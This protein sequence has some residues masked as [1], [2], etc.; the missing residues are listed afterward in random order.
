MRL[1]LFFDKYLEIGVLI[2]ILNYNGIK[3]YIETIFVKLLIDL[4][5][6]DNYCSFFTLERILCNERNFLQEEKINVEQIA[7]C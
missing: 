3:F 5:I 7:V 4:K 2:L 6:I 1:D